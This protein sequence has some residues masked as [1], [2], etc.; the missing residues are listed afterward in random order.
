MTGWWKALGLGMALAVAACSP[1]TTGKANG[2]LRIYNWSDDIDPQLLAQFTKETG[3]KVIYD[4]LDSNEVLETKVL[5]GGTGYDLVVPAN[6]NV[7]RYI[8]AGAIQPAYLSQQ[9]RRP[10]G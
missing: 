7:A 4:T 1:Q 8:A 3:I 10:A 6:N 9:R 5:Q 2:A